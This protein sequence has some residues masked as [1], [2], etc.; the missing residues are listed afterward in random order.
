VAN[1]VDHKTPKRLDPDV[2]VVFDGLLKEANALLGREEVAL[3]LIIDSDDNLVPEGG[4][5]AG[6][7]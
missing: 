4:G 1:E 2:G 3:L 5:P 7:V 6:D